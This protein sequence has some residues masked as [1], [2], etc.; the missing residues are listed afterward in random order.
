MG[1][2]AGVAAIRF[3]YRKGVEHEKPEVKIR[4]VTSGTYV[5]CYL[6]CFRVFRIVVSSMELQF[7]GDILQ[8]A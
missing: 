1:C 2:V 5:M 8:F 4:M 3:T 7:D 6:S